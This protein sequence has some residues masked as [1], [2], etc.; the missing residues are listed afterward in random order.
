M[1][2]NEN[3]RTPEQLVAMAKQMDPALQT[4]KFCVRD[5][6]KSRSWHFEV[7]PGIPNEDAIDKLLRPIWIELAI[8]YELLRSH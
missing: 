3:R 5:N 2:W 1:Q 8:R 7:T 6:S 4:A